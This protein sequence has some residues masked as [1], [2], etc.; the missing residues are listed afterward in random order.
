[1]APAPCAAALVG[2]V[3]GSLP[4]FG[5]LGA[6]RRNARADHWWVRR[7]TIKSG[8]PRQGSSV[9]IGFVAGC[10]AMPSGAAVRR[11]RPASRVQ[12]PQAPALP[13]RNGWPLHPRRRVKAYLEAL[14][15]ATGCGR[16][17]RRPPAVEPPRRAYLQRGRRPE[18]GV[19]RRRLFV[20]IAHSRKPSCKSLNGEPAKSRRFGD[21][22]ALQ[23]NFLKRMAVVSGV[24]GSHRNVP[25][26]DHRD[27]APLRGPRSRAPPRRKRTD[28]RASCLR[29]GVRRSPRHRLRGRRM[30]PRSAWGRG[31][32]DGSFSL[33]TRGG[34]ST[35]K[36]LCYGSGACAS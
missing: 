10:A 29:G 20:E 3:T 16:R 18:G 11:G 27:Q 21:R 12:A 24:A 15:P 23:R 14:K 36:T 7:P 35:T 19:Q 33:A 26:I 22:K 9:S 28:S 4:G 17:A 13:D 5:C 25:L 2:M 31:P 8:H 30:W 34:S 6:Q 1:M 32:P